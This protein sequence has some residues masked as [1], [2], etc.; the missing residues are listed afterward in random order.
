MNLHNYLLHISNFGSCFQF[1]LDETA[2]TWN[3]HD[4]RP[5]GNNSVPFGRPD[6]MFYAPELWQTQLEIS[7]IL[8]KI[9]SQGALFRSVVP[10]GEDVYG[11]CVSIMGRDNT[12]PP[13]TFQKLYSCI[14]ISR[15]RCLF[16][17][18]VC[19]C[20]F[21][22]KWVSLTEKHLNRILNQLTIHFEKQIKCNKSNKKNENATNISVFM[23]VFLWF[24]DLSSNYFV[25]TL[26]IPNRDGTNHFVDRV[27]LM[28]LVIQ[29]LRIRTVCCR[30]KFCYLQSLDCFLFKH[31]C[32][33]I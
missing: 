4:I 3:W 18:N 11:V 7:Y 5:S 29:P 8:F 24:K 19:Y 15:M 17:F 22:G 6:V 27:R 9:H 33:K 14:F 21:K 16:C 25:H 20:A 2:E 32:Q 23:V 1:E 13:K 10:C 30:C 26:R 28:Y 31:S 12:D